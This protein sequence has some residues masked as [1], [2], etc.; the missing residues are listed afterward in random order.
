MSTTLLERDQFL[1]VLEDAL[2]Q[3]TEGHGRIALV[4]G[5]AGIGKTSLVERFLERH[6]PA[7]RTL[8]GGCEALF[9]PR[10]LGPL[11]DIAQQTRT[12]LRTLLDS[13]ANRA[14]L[15]GAVLDDLTQVPAPTVV[16]VEDLHWADEATLDLI[17]FLARRIQRTSTLLILTYRDEELGRDHPLRLVLGDLP[18]RAVT[19]L[20]LPPLSEAA[21]ATLAQKADRPAHGLYLATGGNPFFVRELL[22]SDAPG[23]PT[24]VSDAVLARVARRSP[25]ALCLLEL[26][27]VVPTRV[28]WWVVEGVGAAYSAGLEECLAA[29][30]LHL[31]GEAVSYRHELARQ[32]VEG[33][34]STARRR[35]LHAE[36][37]RALLARGVEQASLARLVHHA[38]AAEDGAL[39]LRF[40][41]AAARQ[42]SA[43]GAHREA[44]A[45]Y[46]TALREAG[47]LDSERRAD[48]LE[49]LS[50]ELYLAGRIRDAVQPCEAALVLWKSLNRQEQVGHDLRRLSRLNWFLGRHAEAEQYGL[51]AVELLEML[52]PSRELA[53]ACANMANLRMVE[54]NIA[55]TKVWGER[56]IALAERLGDTETLSYALTSVGT[57]QLE[58]N[59]E[60]GRAPME[61]S[62]ALALE[63]GYEE[64]VVRAYANLSADSF[65][66]HDYAQAETWIEKGL[67]YCAEH[68]L[69][70]WGH[71]L[72][73]HRSRIRLA[74][75]DWDGVEE[76]ATA[77]LRVTWEDTTNRTPALLVLGQVRARRGDPGAQS[78]LDEA[79][80]VAM[81]ATVLRAGAMDNFVCIAAA[82]AEWRWLQGD[83]AGCVAEANEG[84]QQAL[85][86]PYPWYIGD[87]AIWLWRGDALHEAPAKAFSPFALQIV[88]DWRAA[89]NAWERLGCPY[90]QALALLDG[91]EAAQ[92][93]A[94]AIF[95][96]LGAAPAAEIARQ[97]LRAAGVRGLPRGPRPTTR[98]NPQGL[99]NRQL[100]VL[101]L[102]A[103]GLR[104]PEI[105][106]RLSTTRKT[107][108]HH[109]SAV[110]T[111]L[112]ARSR[113]EAVRVAY[114]LGLIP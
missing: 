48:L 71:Y 83:L 41:P 61:R 54:S 32:A 2:R 72:Q 76:D 8:W 29:G 34:L 109:V 60:R 28:E 31:G 65:G 53:M 92:R 30:L 69:G 11:Y 59:D 98:A 87:V 95:E 27:A 73:G 5:E 103:E 105:A 18:A 81:D 91:D 12:P 24:S 10:P 56:A 50:H 14:T 9:T 3:A 75:G 38:A 43:Q 6:Q 37:L 106:D 45:Y 113:A 111:K 33:A 21:V 22:A 25:A 102:L 101:R 112:E 78:A 96:R 57:I 44:V 100:E 107:V 51:A 36:V 93:G 70:S 17:K 20:R 85:K 108:E 62:L 49:A 82:R 46:Q 58:E 74:R 23:V 84:L 42:A 80:D 13:E 39:V 66:R 114:Q 89:A 79:R 94:L 86:H 1:T 19:R 88:G 26:A 15:F 110:L 97:R 7:L 47:N 63:H 52:P 68:D 99:T 67:A 104:N 4:S 16:V 90:E 35:V 55:D 77:V 40:A 64:H